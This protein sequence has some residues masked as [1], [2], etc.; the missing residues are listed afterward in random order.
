MFYDCRL[1]AEPDV[2]AGSVWLSRPWR[3]YG[4]TVFI[5]CEMGRHIRP[6]GWNNWGN[7]ENEKTSYYAEYVSKGE[8]AYPDKRAT[9][10]HQLLNIEGY[11]IEDVLKGN[12]GWNPCHILLK[13]FDK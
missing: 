6:E 3:P 12:D 13:G 7:A 8:G 11:A 9:W 5:R 2:E 4:K 10:S 1:T